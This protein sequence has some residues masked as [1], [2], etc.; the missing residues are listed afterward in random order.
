MNISD[1]KLGL[2]QHQYCDLYA[3]SQSF[4][5]IFAVPPDLDLAQPPP[6]ATPETPKNLP[7][8]TPR[9]ALNAPEEPALNRTPPALEPEIAISP[10]LSVYPTLDL[11]L[12]IMTVKLQLFDGNA[13]TEEQLRSCGIARFA[14][15][16]N[17]LRFKQFSNGAGE[18]ELI[19][20]SFTVS[21]TRPGP[22]KFR[23]IIPAARHDRNQ[24]MVLFT[25]SG[26]RDNSSLAIVT[27]ESP[28]FLFTLDPVFALAMFFT[29]AFATTG[30]EAQSLT[31]EQTTTLT[32][33]KSKTDMESSP[34]QPE[35]SF[36]FRVD[37]NDVSVTLLENDTDVH[38]QAVRLSVQQVMMSQQG[39]LALTVT[40]LGMSLTQMGRPDESVKFMDDLDITL[41]ME[42]KHVMALQR[43]NVEITAKP[44][45]FRAS[46][47]DINLILAIVARASQ[48]ASQ[49]SSLGSNQQSAQSTSRKTVATT[50]AHTTSEEKPRLVMSTEKVL[51]HQDSWFSLTL[52]AQRDVRWI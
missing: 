14:L 13:L 27:I 23:E 8:P 44:I 45:V 3:L 39:I 4:T 30:G 19:L 7:P 49:S 11:E 35:S 17:S 6:Q 40:Q 21:N 29:S 48:L 22:S 50:K 12:K 26:G 5:R 51:S 16:G 15:S 20:K 37:L 46:Q 41:S 1:I 36:A 33:S 28:K 18:A 47:R 42:S 38:S 34:P 10:R 2:T 43:T 9:G 25:M 24:F 31:G 52:V 32:T